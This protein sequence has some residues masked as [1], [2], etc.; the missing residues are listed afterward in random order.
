MQKKYI[1]ATTAAIVILVAGAVTYKVCAEKNNG[2]AAIVNGEQITVAE[3]Q[4]AYDQNP[5]L[6]A[7]VSFNEFYNRALDVMVNGKLVLQAATA[8][9]IQAS[10]EYQKQLASV[11]EDLA[12]KV[13]ID[14]QVNAQVT[15][16]AAKKVYD[17]YVAS[18][19]SEKEIKAKHILV[20]DESAAK[21]VIKQLNK[22]ASFDDLAKEYSKDQADLGYFTAQMMV[23]EFSEAA[24]SMEKGS[25]SKEPVKTEFG[26]HVILVE[27]IRDTKP[28]SYEMI[29]SQVKANL[30]QQAVGKVLE[31]LT[32]S[33]QIEK[34]D[35]DGKKI[36][37]EK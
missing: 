7:Q 30:A 28:L 18:F 29:E 20:D 8:A 21:E 12:R 24:F 32:S 33:A 23:P 5:Q 3:I 19:K 25:Y 1:F 11:Q 36:I 6:Q 26:Y 31:N 15:D 35:L 2:I 37:E 4:E 9:N 22:K 14:Q 16:E 13:Y 27:D 34:F 10:P 17:D